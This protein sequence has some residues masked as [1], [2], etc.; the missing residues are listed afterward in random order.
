MFVP[1]ALYY[2]VFA[3]LPMTGIVMA[4]KQFNYRQGIWMS[5]WNG[6]Q[7]FEFFFKSGKAL[8]VTGN[9][10]LYNL[11]FLGCY[12]LFSMLI[13]I[14]IAELPGRM[15]KK[16]L[17]SSLFLP[18]FISWVVVAAMVYN[19]LNYDHGLIN[20]LF[21][22]LG[23]HSIDIYAKQK[24]WYFLLPLLYVWKW[25]GFGSVV[26]LA[27]IMGIDQEQY[28]AA[29][30]DGV[31][32]IQKIWFITLPALRSTMII[33]V[34]LGLGRIMRGEFEMFFQLIGNNGLLLDATDLI[35]TLVFRAVLVTNDINMASAVG[36]YQSVI[37]FCIILG[38][39]A[40]VRKWEKE[41]ALF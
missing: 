27:A 22:V 21:T 1:V 3:Y 32:V 19:L 11:I 9:T 37:G 20:K 31:N 29:V 2:L 18:Y 41:N 5:P 13:A 30:I 14:I 7:N 6:L 16:V 8:L 34:L 36:F 35:D 4:F 17:Q 10:I 33:L 25:I 15:F 12:T 26:Y 24:Y 38:A 39:N 28:E 40:L 23:Y